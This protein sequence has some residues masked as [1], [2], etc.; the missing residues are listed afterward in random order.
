MSNKIGLRMADIMSFRSENTRTSAGKKFKFGAFPETRLPH[1]RD[2]DFSLEF[3]SGEN[4]GLSSLGLLNLSSNSGLST[5]GSLVDSK[6]W[7]VLR[8]KD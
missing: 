4:S 1:K 6:P 2:R 3:Y 5:K 8:K 7:R